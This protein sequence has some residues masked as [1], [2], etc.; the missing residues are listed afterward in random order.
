VKRFDLC[1]AHKEAVQL[2]YPGQTNVIEEKKQN[3]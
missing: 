2:A 1:T 3:G